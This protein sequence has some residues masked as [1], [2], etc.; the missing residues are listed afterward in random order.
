MGRAND[1]EELDVRQA[2]QRAGRTAETI[3]R[4]VWTGRLDAYKRG[5]K[6]MIHA[7]ELDALLSAKPA[8][9]PLSLAQWAATA[10]TR[11]LPG[12]AAGTNSSAADLIFE[13]RRMRAGRAVD[14]SR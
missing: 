1:V 4:W 12:A 13:D 3:R 5:N 2:A 7:S 11:S 9:T 8:S 6:L 10:N 14:A